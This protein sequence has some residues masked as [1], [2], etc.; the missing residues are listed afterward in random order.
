[1]T[2]NRG[3]SQQI[4]SSLNPCYKIN[5]GNKRST[6]TLHEKTNPQYM[7]PYATKNNQIG[8]SNPTFSP[9]LAYSF[10]DAA[11]IQQIVY[12]TKIVRKVSE[13]YFF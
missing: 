5:R 13:V 4:G 11:D 1:M 7:G 3:T 9:T 8:T 12:R 10:C 2:S 6:T